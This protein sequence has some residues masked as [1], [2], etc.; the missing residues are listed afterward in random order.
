MSINPTSTPSS[1]PSQATQILKSL[2]QPSA[3]SRQINHNSTGAITTKTFFEGHTQQTTKVPHSILHNSMEELSI[4]I[5]STLGKKAT[6]RTSNNENDESILQQVID[7]L[8]ESDAEGLLQKFT[9][10]QQET[11]EKLLQQHVKNGKDPY[12]F[13]QE[14]KKTFPKAADQYIALQA[15]KLKMIGFLNRSGS[16]INMEDFDKY[17]KT[18]GVLNEELMVLMDE[19]TSEIR[20]ALNTAAIV[21]E[22]SEKIS[23][24][25]EVLRQFYRSAVLR[26]KTPKE[27]L[28]YIIEKFGADKLDDSMDFLSKS[29][30]TDMRTLHSSISKNQLKTIISDLYNLA[31]LKHVSKQVRTLVAQSKKQLECGSK[32]T[33]QEVMNSILEMTEKSWLSKVDIDKYLKVFQAEKT[34]SI[35]PI[36]TRTKEI[37]RLLPDSL[38]ADSK[39][40]NKLMTAIFESI[41]G[42]AIQELRDS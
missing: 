23:V 29:V 15:M 28:K 3:P 40:R 19:K 1:T 11:I 14:F 4:G 22:F 13:L 32:T 30:S 27:L 7:D 16:M 25:S 6:K 17:L 26:Y 34:T 12:L 33:S 8:H 10:Q 42:Y 38:Y 36:L 31:S 9:P 20:A 35:I 37:F 5:A 39:T 41:N 21:K 18:V 24:S 2:D